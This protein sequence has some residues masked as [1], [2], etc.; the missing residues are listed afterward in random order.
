MLL[1]NG[2]L[3]RALRINKNTQLML[4]TSE[5]A[6]PFWVFAASWLH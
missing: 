6:L 3:I 1:R 4:Q 5:L 2:K